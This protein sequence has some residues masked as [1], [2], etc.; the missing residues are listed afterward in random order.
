MRTTNGLVLVSRTG[1]EDWT[2]SKWNEHKFS[3]IR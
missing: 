2:W 3:L 1:D